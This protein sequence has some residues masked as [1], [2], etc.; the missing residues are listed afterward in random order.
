MLHPL[1]VEN[2]FQP[3]NTGGGGGDCRGQ[4]QQQSPLQDSRDENQPNTSKFEDEEDNLFG[5][6]FDLG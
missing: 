5:P 4:Q 3:G 6:P 1:G 2:P